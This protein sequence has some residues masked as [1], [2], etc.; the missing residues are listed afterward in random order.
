MIDKFVGENRFLSN[1]GP[2]EI[3]YEGEVYL[4]S[5]HFYQAA[6]TI[7]DEE[8]KFVRLAPTPGEA[9]KRGKKIT[10][11]DD[12]DKVK[13]GIMRKALRLKFE[14]NPELAQKLLD[15]GDQELIEGNT[16]GDVEWGVCFGTGQNKLGL[17]LQ[18]RRTAMQEI[19]KK[20]FRSLSD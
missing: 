18:E 9:K 16:W 12:W 4:T 2:G 17:M 1:F 13:D 5:E 8:Q 19:Q 20:H 3:E 6:K 11:R 10:L 14:Q 7:D 15:T